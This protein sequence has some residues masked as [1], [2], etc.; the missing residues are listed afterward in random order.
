MR[1][2]IA[3]LLAAICL[4]WIGAAQDQPKKPSKQ[5]DDSPPAQPASLKGI[6]IGEDTGRPLRRAQVALRPAQAGIHGYTAETDDHG[7]FEFP[8]VSPGNYSI[9]VQRDGY[10]PSSV[11]KLGPSRLPVIFPIR[12]AANLNDVTVRL[13][14]W[15]VIA[16]K[17]K[18]DDGEPAINVA[19]QLYREY[20]YRG[21]HGYRVAGGARTD[22]RGEYRAHGLEPGVY[23]VAALFQKPVLLA[24]AEQTLRR[25]QNGLPLP[26]LRY[27]VTFY[28]SSPKMLEATPVRVA[29]GQE[30][31]VVDI[32]LTPVPTVRV[33]GNVI[34]GLSGRVIPS[35]AIVLRRADASET[36]SVNAPVDLDY[37][38]E[39][40]FVLKGVVPGAYYFVMNGSEN[41]KP[42]TSRQ[43]Y[44]V[45][46]AGI[47]NMTIVL[48]PPAKWKGKIHVDGGE[49]N[50]AS[51]RVSLEPRRETAARV[52]T[53]VEKD[54]SFAIDFTPGEP[55]DL[56]VDGAA[57]DAYLKY[58]RLA[59]NDVLAS[60]IKA[61]TGE[62]PFPLDIALATDGGKLV[63]RVMAPD[64]TVAT[65]ATV[66]LVPDPVVGRVQFYK[67]AYADENGVF[68]FQGIAPGRYIALAWLDEAPCEV[69]DPNAT[70]YCRSKGQVV[71][72]AALSQSALEV[73]IAE[74]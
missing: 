18:F 25:D 60:G 24:G 13:T 43:L 10:L 71:D 62:E 30:I 73:R 4:I 48:L 42:L 12:E 61:D 58:V 8:T 36:A 33:R 31:N 6:V 22:D 16:G 52:L 51:L 11:A 17:V 20:F 72:V 38:R 64:N 69:Y 74:Q 46:E 35:P 1:R 39:A 56:V 63:G 27:A 3:L 55:Y 28:P 32:V 50:L 7:Q 23:Y 54:G 29:R 53:S 65:G 34:S 5:P 2:P 70:A 40:S 67:T 9:G 66:M 26:E 59:N 47:D 68:Y 49:T 44:T 37:D 21:L 41:N 19:V 57:P 45:G 14:P 15:G